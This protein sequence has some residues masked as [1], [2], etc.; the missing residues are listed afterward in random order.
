[1]TIS[2]ETIRFTIQLFC[3]A[4]M[5]AMGLGIT[6]NDIQAPFRKLL[7]LA[8]II[9]VNNVLIPLLGFLI[10]AVPA[11]LQWPPLTSVAEQL[12]P[13]N[14]GQQI[15]FLLLFLAA[16]NF[17][18]P[19][20]ARMAGAT[21]AFAKGMMVVLVGVSALLVPFELALFARFNDMVGDAA[22]AFEP[23]PI[24]MTLLYYQLLP[25]ALG[26]VIKELYDA[27]A[28]QL[29]PLLVQLTGLSLL[30]LVAML[31]VSG[32]LVTDLLGAAPV[33]PTDL[34]ASNVLTSTTTLDEKQV[35]QAFLDEIEQANKP[36]PSSPALVVLETGARWM[37]VDAET[38]YTVRV[39]SSTITLP[40]TP[41]VTPTVM[42]TVTPT[43][44]PTVTSTMTPTVTLTVTPTNTPTI[45]PTIPS[46][47]TP[48]VT[49]TDT[50]EPTPTPAATDGTEDLPTPILTFTPIPTPT[51]FDLATDTPTP[52]AALQA[53]EAVS[54]TLDTD[55]ETAGTATASPTNTLISTA[56]PTVSP[57]VT[58][59]VTST[60]TLTAT[61]VATATVTPPISA[62]ITVTVTP[63]AT[64]V[65]TAAAPPVL[66]VLAIDALTPTFTIA[67]TAS[68]LKLRIDELNARQMSAALVEKFAAAELGLRA[69]MVVVVTENQEWVLVNNR[70]TYFIENKK[71]PFQVYQELA[72]PFELIGEFL[73]TL[74]G[75]PVIGPVIDFLGKL[76]GLLLPYAMFAALSL[77]LLTIGRYCGTAV[78][79][80]IGVTGPTIPQTL[81]TSTAVRNVTFAL[82]IVANH[83]MEQ[84][85]LGKNAIA[86]I[87]IF[88]LVSLIVAARQAVQWGAEA[89]ANTTVTVVHTE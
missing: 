68:E 7:A 38:A 15:G 54:P 44:I 4:T 25:L 67:A 14:G 58:S 10:M 85:D 17:L 18:A 86:V 80:I 21:D 74:E 55:D 22:S 79:G 71:P 75:L 32:Q 12:V 40:V 88:F 29:R 63:T 53:R 27:I 51:A 11:V 24:F 16:G 89:A 69:N 6:F 28:V 48:T 13:L 62:T 52:E 42:P 1:M 37:L 8:V 26:I 72:Q 43:I 9:L 2:S 61:S 65:I 46:T 47:I 83:L 33:V 5:A 77:L 49:A 76:V 23:A 60:V 73:K 59:T 87:L 70:T 50:V 41:T 57:T 84:D 66:A 64:T 34:F 31:A 35:P 39:I 19:V 30:V 36:T 82:I 3:I 45:T 78:Q 81:A 20:L 56:P